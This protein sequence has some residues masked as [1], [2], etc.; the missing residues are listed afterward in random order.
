MSIPLA[1]APQLHC[2]KPAIMAFLARLF[3]QP[4]S[5][6]LRA[7]NHNTLQGS[8]EEDHDELEGEIAEVP[9]DV[10]KNREERSLAQ[11]NTG[12]KGSGLGPRKPLCAPLC[13]SCRSA[14]R[15]ASCVVANVGV[16]VFGCFETGCRH[17]R[18]ILFHPR[19]ENS[20]CGF[21]NKST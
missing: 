19:T 5:R 15:P 11:N 9:V 20:Q 6:E 12:G 2:G 10:L 13:P 7:T 8:Y 4:S 21:S 17:G 3:N 1:W 18:Q 16:R 14:R